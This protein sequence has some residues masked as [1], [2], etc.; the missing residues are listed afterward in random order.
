MTSFGSIASILKQNLTSL[1]YFLPRTLP[2]PSPIKLFQESNNIYFA[3]QLLCISTAVFGIL[4]LFFFSLF[5]TASFFPFF[6]AAAVL[7]NTSSWGFA[8]RL[9]IDFFC[10]FFLLFSLHFL[11]LC[12]FY[13][14]ALFSVLFF[15][16]HTSFLFSPFG[17]TSFSLNHLERQPLR[18]WVDFCILFLSLFWPY[19]S[20]FLS[21]NL[22]FDHLPFFCF[23]LSVQ[24]FSPHI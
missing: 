6:Q 15:T 21:F 7:W 19:S 5:L 24:L 18:P 2:S 20:F 23:L 22:I 9:S 3:M 12:I 14:F 16:L 1:F 8:S 13:Y 17:L 4:C 10:V 11:P